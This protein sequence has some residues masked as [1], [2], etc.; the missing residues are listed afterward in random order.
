MRT[1]TALA[2]QSSLASLPSNL[3]V[4]KNISVRKDVI[5][6]CLL[7]KTIMNMYGSVIGAILIAF[8]SGMVMFGVSD[9]SLIVEMLIVSSYNILVEAFVIIIIIRIVIDI[10]ATSVNV[11]GN[12]ATSM[13]INRF[14]E[15][16]VKNK[17]ISK[18]NFKQSQSLYD[19]INNCC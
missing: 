2:T 12:T 7:I 16:W 1:A 4:T 6:V 8:L 5:K 17:R 11:V 9:G 19:V 10:P 14:T 3:E 13:L 18:T 15:K